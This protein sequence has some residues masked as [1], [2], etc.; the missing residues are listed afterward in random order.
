[1]LF[2]TIPVPDDAV[3]IDLDAGRA[4]LNLHNICVHDVFTVPNSFNIAHPLGFVGAVI[5]S[6]KIQWSGVIQSFLGFS[7]SAEQFVGNFFQ[8]SATIAVTTN[9]PATSPPF[10]P[11]LQHGFQFVAD[12]TTTVTN[13]AQIG[14][15]RNGHFF[16]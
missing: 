10:T 15:E 12:P 3:V 9:T 13:F 1:L 2:W 4:K 14:E 6:L 7:S 11:S 16:S 5:K 8:T